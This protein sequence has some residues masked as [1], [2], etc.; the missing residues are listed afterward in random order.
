MD[1]PI[2]TSNVE[3]N[4][5]VDA[6]NDKALLP[7]PSKSAPTSNIPVEICLPHPST[8]GCT[9]IIPPTSTSQSTS[10]INQRST[11]PS[12][13]LVSNLVLTT[14]TSLTFT[15]IHQY[16]ILEDPLVSSQSIEPIIN[17]VIELENL[18]QNDDFDFGLISSNNFARDIPDDGIMYGYQYTILNNKLSMLLYFL[19]HCLHHLLYLLQLPKNLMRRFLS[20]MRAK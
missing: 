5:N 6:Q 11:T 8:F 20:F 12:P 18:D 17:D 19:Y 7:P 10:T 2:N 13:P 4:I 16:K 9:I 15:T 3:A 1:V 14:L